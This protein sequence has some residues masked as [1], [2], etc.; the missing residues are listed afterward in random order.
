M[1]TA[2]K[3][4]DQNMQTYNDF[5]WKLNKWVKTNGEGELCGSGWLHFCIHPLLAI[6]LNPIHADIVPP[7]RLFKAQVKGKCKTDNG[8]KV[9]YTCGKLVKEL[10]V[11]V[12]TI[13]QRIAFGI[14]CAQAVY[15]E[16]KWNEWA[17]NWLNDKDRTE[18]TAWIAAETAWAARAAA[19]GARAASAAADG[20]RA[21]ASAAIAAETAWAAAWAAARA[22]VKRGKKFNLTKLAKKAY[23]FDGKKQQYQEHGET[24]A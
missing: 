3:L 14:F 23:A 11:P 13:E 17:E 8:L 10:A 5:Q 16:E 12:F 21:A 19:D 7:L 6:L 24:A 22:A 9:G 15:K 4:T 1:K 20:A 18:K 2:Y